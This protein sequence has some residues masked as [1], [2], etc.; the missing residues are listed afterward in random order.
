MPFTNTLYADF[1]SDA[2]SASPGHG[3]VDRH[4]GCASIVGGKLIVGKELGGYGWLNN[5]IYAPGTD[6]E[7]DSEIEFLV[8]AGLVYGDGI[9]AVLRSQSYQL[10]GGS[11]PWPGQNGGYEMEMV[12]AS[13]FGTVPRFKVDAI[14]S[15]NRSGSPLAGYFG[16]FLN[17]YDTAKSYWV[18][19][20]ITGATNP[21]LFLD[22]WENNGNTVTGGD[23][24][25]AHGPN[26]VTWSAT[27]DNSG[28]DF[29]YLQRPGV[30]AL[31]GD[32]VAGA[33][34]GTWNDGKIEAVRFATQPSSVPL[35]TPVPT[36]TS[37]TATVNTLQ[38]SPSGG[39]TPYS[40][41]WY[42][43]VGDPSLPAISGNL[44]AAATSATL[45]HTHGDAPGTLRFY[46][47]AATDAASTSLT[48]AVC[49][50][51]ALRPA[52]ALPTLRADL[53]AGRKLVYATW[54]DSISAAGNIQAQVFANLAAQGITNVTLVNG[55]QQGSALTGDTGWSPTAPNPYPNNNWSATSNLF[56]NFMSLI[57]TAMNANPGALLVVSGMILTND[58]QHFSGGV[59]SNATVQQTFQDI[60]NAVLVHFPDA[61]QIINCQPYG[62]S[63]NISDA[64]HIAEL[65]WRDATVS[66]VNAAVSAGQMVSLG[67]RAAYYAVY[68]HPEWLA[69]GIHPNSTGASAV[70]DLHADALMRNVLAEP[71]NM[72]NYTL[73]EITDALTNVLTTLGYTGPR[74]AKLD[75]LDAAVS[76]RLS[77]NAY[78]A[79]ASTSAI[80][81]AV[82]TNSTRTITG[83]GSGSGGVSVVQGPFSLSAEVG[84]IVD[85]KMTAYTGDVLPILVTLR[86]DSGDLI[87]YEANTLSAEIT[88][89]SGAVT[90]GNLT[91]ESI[92][93]AYGIAK[94]TVPVAA[95]GTYRLTVRKT[96]TN[97]DVVTFG[98]I[99][100]T[101]S[102]R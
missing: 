54:G 62:T 2:D 71:Q 27:H 63:G 73:S 21:T 94:V 56:D 101:V 87:S 84:G 92:A 99:V 58:A 33:N 76:S 29:L 77:S 4:G 40:Y 15:A 39:S 55:A 38:A 72:E 32:E 42:S 86:T 95:R 5:T 53:I 52:L 74:A 59:P 20:R 6:A 48:S 19:F 14:S 28:A 50:V 100:I 30:A 36:T 12:F 57:T 11:D 10:Q 88:D 81:S 44:V 90:A 68:A 26:V 7:L 69:D 49:M 80:A 67:D 64:A 31:I 96:A 13:G 78:A 1:R 75:N 79:P 35:S 25:A 60:F 9:G 102:N 34:G 22:V 41:A 24:A 51:E 23:T 93:P 61:L 89:V 66:A 17:G 43:K 91:I 65:G 47:Y 70:G 46:R 3:L 82:W 16:L 8:P 45:A 85:G 18:R 98:V 97:G 37:R 83:G